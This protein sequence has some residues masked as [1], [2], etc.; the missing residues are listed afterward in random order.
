MLLLQLL[1]LSLDGMTGGIQDKLRSEHETQTHRMMFSMNLWS[2]LYLSLG[3]FTV[4]WNVYLVSVLI[5]F[6]LAPLTC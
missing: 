4:Q 2:I 3:E 6:L 1:S 5:D